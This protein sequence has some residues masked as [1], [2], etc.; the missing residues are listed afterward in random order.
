M[1]LRIAEDAVQLLSRPSLLMH[2]RVLAEV[3]GHVELSSP[4]AGPL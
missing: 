2:L 4:S 1:G 3:L